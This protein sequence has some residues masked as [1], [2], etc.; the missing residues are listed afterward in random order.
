MS[1]KVIIIVSFLKLLSCGQTSERLLENGKS[2]L[3]FI[4]D[5]VQIPIS[6]DEYFAS[7]Q[8]H[9]L[10]EEH[11]TFLLRES[12]MKNSIEVYDWEGKNKHSR[13]T[14][15][16]EGPNSVRSFGSSAIYP[17]K[18]DS[19]FLANLVGDIYFTHRDSVLDTRTINKGYR[20]FGENSFKPTR[21]GE[22]IFV[23]KA[24]NF[25]QTN[26]D[27]YK[28]FAIVSY[29]I[30]D[31]QVE[32]IPVE[33]PE[34]FKNNCWSE[35]HWYVPFTSNSQGHLVISFSTG[36]EILVYDPDNQKVVASHKVNSG[37]AGTVDPLPNCDTNDLERYHRYL[38]STPRYLSLTFDPFKNV[39]Y[40][41]IALT[42]PGVADGHRNFVNVQ[43]LSVMVLDTNFN[44][45]AEKKFPGRK[46]DPLDFFVTEEG[47][48]LSR[49]NEEADDFVR[50]R[51]FFDLIN[52]T[53][54]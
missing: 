37:L 4:A 23:H 2:D 30:T 21:I 52:F 51:L 39:Y 6:P 27:F 48:W 47:L 43:P 44:V 36:P 46:Y 41:I 38:K 33:F 11:N 18:L 28:D 25:R 13:I 45:I 50:N 10:L 31:G 24:S 8:N 17:F 7:I 53:K 40:R 54:T 5:S 22:K 32:P 14:F 19:V 9:I 35:H 49:N 16:T 1:K 20:F 34:K 15:K 29:D 26:P 3:I 42:V 12:R